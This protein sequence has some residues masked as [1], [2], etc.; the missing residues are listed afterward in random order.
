MNTQ[1]KFYGP[2]IVQVTTIKSYAWT[3]I[4]PV[5]TLTKQVQ[6][7]HGAAL[8]EGIA[9]RLNKLEMDPFLVHKVNC[10]ISLVELS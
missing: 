4:L 1:S 5:F 10:M 6:G 7:T 3:L 8:E 2:I 9:L